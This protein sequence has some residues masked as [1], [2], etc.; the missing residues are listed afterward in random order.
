MLSM[1]GSEFISWSGKE[2]A[3]VFFSLTFPSGEKIELLDKNTSPR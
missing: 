3:Q 2:S 1:E